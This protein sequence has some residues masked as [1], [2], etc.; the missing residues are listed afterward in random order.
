MPTKIKTNLQIGLMPPD[1]KKFTI[2]KKGEVYEL[3]NDVAARLIKSG[4]AVKA[5]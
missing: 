3:N 5:V 4:S 2:L 1:V